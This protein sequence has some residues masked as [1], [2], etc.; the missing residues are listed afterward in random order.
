MT[1]VVGAPGTTTL[2]FKRLGRTVVL[3][4]PGGGSDFENTLVRLAKY[5]AGGRLA[6]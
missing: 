2:V 4:A 1:V 6:F 5:R 3:T